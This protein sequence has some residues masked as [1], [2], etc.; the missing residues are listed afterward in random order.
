[1]TTPPNYSQAEIDAAVKIIKEDAI[2]QHNA[3]MAD[4]M[5]RIEERLGRMPVK[6]M[7][8]EEKAAEYDRIMA[9]GGP[10]PPAADPPADPPKPPGSPVPPEPK[11][12]ADPKPARK[13]PY[14]GDALS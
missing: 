11:P 1:M 3:A 7:S 13:D 5:T 6:E 10:K 9:Q 4:R 8:P 12:P 14:W 2:I